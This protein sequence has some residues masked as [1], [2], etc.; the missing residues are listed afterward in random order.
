MAQEFIDFNQLMREARETPGLMREFRN[1]MM[2]SKLEKLLVKM[3]DEHKQENTLTFEKET[4]LVCS[5]LEMLVK[6]KDTKWDCFLNLKRQVLCVMIT[7]Y[8]FVTIH[9]DDWDEETVIEETDKRLTCLC[10]LLDDNDVPVIDR[11]DIF[12]HIAEVACESHAVSVCKPLQ[13]TI[14]EILVDAM[15]EC[16]NSLYDDAYFERMLMH[17]S[18]C[19]NTRRD[20]WLPD[21]FHLMYLDFKE[22][23]SQI[24]RGLAFMENTTSSKRA[25]TA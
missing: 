3:L 20:W 1:T 22:R 18:I 11:I 25:P 16:R 15:L 10:E 9:Y 23:A 2:E 17:T 12:V 7:K 21:L 14:V 6:S 4:K 13:A 19:R 5:I 8:F 24:K